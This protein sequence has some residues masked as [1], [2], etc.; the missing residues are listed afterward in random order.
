MFS[1]YLLFCF[2]FFG[3]C[4][5]ASVMDIIEVFQ[6]FPLYLISDIVRVFSLYDGSCSCFA[7]VFDHSGSYL[8]LAGS[9]IR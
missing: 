6:F 1:G 4:L 8:A 5:H 7:V 3:V 9:D 2:V